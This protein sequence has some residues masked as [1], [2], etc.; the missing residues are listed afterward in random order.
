MQCALFNVI[1]LEQSKLLQ[2]MNDNNSQSYYI[3]ILLRE[4]V[5]GQGQFELI[6]TL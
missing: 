4:A 2:K 5:F 6:K 1:I 3:K